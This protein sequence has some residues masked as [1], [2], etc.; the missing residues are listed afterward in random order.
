MPKMESLEDVGG[1]ELSCETE[2]MQAWRGILG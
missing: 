2:K 1:V